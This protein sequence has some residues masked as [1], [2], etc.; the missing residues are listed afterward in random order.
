MG[1]LSSGDAS[2]DAALVATIDD[3]IGHL[4]YI[5]FEQG[6][7][8]IRATVDSNEAALR[9]SLQDYEQGL[10]D[11][12]RFVRVVGVLPDALAWS[13]FKTQLR[14]AAREAGEEISLRTALDEAL[15]RAE[16]TLLGDHHVYAAWRSAMTEL[17]A[18][19][20]ATVGGKRA[21]PAHGEDPLQWA[22]KCLADLEDH[23]RFHSWFV[24]DVL[25][26]VVDPDTAG[27][28]VVELE[29]RLFAETRYDLVLNTALRF[30]AGEFGVHDP[31]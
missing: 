17:V 6:W 21:H 30:L 23:Q 27:S 31:M 7:E 28:S 29:N 5:V 4:Q 20:A 3:A 12:L 16:T 25:E 14:S 2:W 8:R 10:F 13:T 26:G 22:A 19:R 15:Y 18:S 24:A 11:I 9:A 1:E